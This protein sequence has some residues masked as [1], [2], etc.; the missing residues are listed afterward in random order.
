MNFYVTFG[1]ADYLSTIVQKYPEE[2]LLLMQ[3]AEKSVLFH[4]TVGESIFKEPHR[5]EVL[6]HSGDIIKGKFAVLNNIPVTDEGRP[7]F[8]HRF[9]QRAGLIE[10]EP[11]FTA[12]RV[13]RPI[14]SDTYVI[15]TLW[16]NEDAFTNWQKS[17]SF[18]RAHQKRESSEDVNQKSVFPRSSFVTSYHAIEIDE[19]K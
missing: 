4:E 17:K 16:E 18:E 1:T 8:E 9:K 7:L 15:L 5:Y 11:G 6:D 2:K 12:I 13:L 3:N 14:S 19:E 10:S